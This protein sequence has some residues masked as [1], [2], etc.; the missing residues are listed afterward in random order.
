VLRHE[1]A[2]SDAQLASFLDSPVG[3]FEVWLAERD[4]RRRP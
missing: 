2:G 1:I 4:R 3:R